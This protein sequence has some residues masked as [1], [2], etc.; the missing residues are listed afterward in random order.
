LLSV[1]T[2]PLD[3][4]A[5]ILLQIVQKS[6]AD[7]ESLQLQIIKVQ[8]TLS[9]LMGL[10]ETASQFFIHAIPPQ[11]ILIEIFLCCT[12]IVNH[13]EVDWSWGGTNYDSLCPLNHP[14]NISHIS[15]RWREIALSL[16]RLWSE[17]YLDFTRYTS[18]SLD[19]ALLSAKLDLCVNIV[20]GEMD[21][22][23]RPL[24]PL[25][26]ESTTRWRILNA[27]MSS[28]SLQ[29]LSGCEFPLL[30]EL[31]VRDENPGDGTDVPVDTFRN[32]QNV[33]IMHLYSSDTGVEAYKTLGEFPWSKLL[34]LSCYSSMLTSDFL[35][36]LQ[37]LTSVEELTMTAE[38]ITESLLDALSGHL[39]ILPALKRLEVMNSDIEGDDIE[40]FDHILRIPSIS[41]LTLSFGT[42]QTSGE[43][44]Y[45]GG[46]KMLLNFLRPLS[47]VEEFELKDE[48]VTAEFLDGLSVEEAEKG[49]V[50]LPSLTTLDLHECG[51]PNIDEARASLRRI[52]E[53][54]SAV[55]VALGQHIS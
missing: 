23:Y 13:H 10:Q 44:D 18:F 5:A 38:Y 42:H 12:P 31:G 22:G 28:P 11:D 25:L 20:S 36:G 2:P 33:T 8:E 46:T 41:C 39:I 37:Q 51:F 55:R 35:P 1:N 7:I 40:K 43:L 52:A 30:Q 49:A 48:N 50:L 29:S 6:S 15:H 17:I 54:R 26:K 21:I 32:V 19:N 24:I 27:D 3:A 45:I 9:A 4:E 16:P 47:G 34:K 53:S 14:W